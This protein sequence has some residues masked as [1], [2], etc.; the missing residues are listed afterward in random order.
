MWVQ[1]ILPEHGL[2]EILSSFDN[3]KASLTPA[4]AIE[5]LLHIP[6]TARVKKSNIVAF[7]ERFVG[8]NSNLKLGHV[9]NDTWVAGMVT[10]HEIAVQFDILVLTHL[11]GG[12]SSRRSWSVALDFC[13]DG[14]GVESN[15]GGEFAGELA[16]SMLDLD[17]I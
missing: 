8:N 2:V 17:E 3:S 9:E 10:I 11:N 12:V 5:G 14:P 6:F 7:P 15:Q 16:I 1:P 4:L 13:K